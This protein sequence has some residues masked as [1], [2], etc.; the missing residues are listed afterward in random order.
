MNKSYLGEAIR[1]PIR[2]ET[3]AGA[4]ILALTVTNILVDFAFESDAVFDSLVKT[5]EFTLEE[6]S[7]G[8]YFLII[9]ATLNTEV[10]NYQVVVRGDTCPTI[11]TKR[12]SG[13]VQA[14]DFSGGAVYF[15]SV[16]GAAGTAWPLGEITHPVSNFDNAVTIALNNNLKV[17]KISGV[18]TSTPTSAVDFFTLIGVSNGSANNRPEFSFT[19]KAGSDKAIFIGLKLTGTQGDTDGNRKFVDCEFA[20]ASIKLIGDHLK[21]CYF[22]AV[23]NYTMNANCILDNP[24]FK[25][26]TLVGTGDL[27]QIRKGSGELT[28][29]FST[30]G[31]FPM[32]YFGFEGKLIFQDISGTFVEVYN[33][34]GE[35]D[36]Q[37]TCIDGTSKVVGGIGKLTDNSTGTHV[38]TNE[39]FIDR[40]SAM[41]EYLG[42]VPRYT[43]AALLLAPGGAGGDWTANE[44][45]QIKAMLGAD[46]SGGSPVGA[47]VSEKAG[48]KGTDDIHDTMALESTA[49][50]RDKYVDFFNKEVLARSG[51]EPSQ[52][53]LGTS[54]NAKTIDV[55]HVVIGSEKKA[56]KETVV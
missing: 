1:I 37:A 55:D 42:G 15:N 46:D 29:N 56:D 13:N 6:L 48:T 21:D 5:T 39:G 22:S 38:H 20:S 11:E 44:K 12:Y 8:Q 31:A 40:F 7:L 35:V 45:A 33:P 51:D 47:L 52:Y 41:I 53:K 10:Q 43:A 54:G 26:A 32:R 34:G 25:G 23:G 4:D 3:A 36:F 50:T 2:L 14:K 24:I 16:V 9:N 49:L 28:N 27:L 17:I 19:N 18:V 30:G